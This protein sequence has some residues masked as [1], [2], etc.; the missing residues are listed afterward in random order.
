[1][2]HFVGDFVETVI[3]RYKGSI[4]TWEL[5]GRANSADVLALGEE[6]LLRLAVHA[7][8]TS[9]AIDADARYV[10]RIGQPWGQYLSR[11]GRQLAPLHFADT[12]LRAD[13]GVSGFDLEICVGYTRD[14]SPPRDLMELSRLL[15]LWSTLGVPLALTLAYPSAADT[16]PLATKDAAMEP[17]AA[18]S[19]WNEAAQAQWVRECVS[20]ALAKP[21]VQTVAWA[22]LS[23]AGPHEWP[24]A[25]LVRAD[26][27]PKRALEEL[28]TLR[29]QFLR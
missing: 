23:D 29:G 1:L 20:L 9:R 28:A 2:L 15:D 4:H 25:G 12:L 17:S 5:V 13:L 6:Q 14:A 27:A 26:G 3:R 22:H 8:E 7:L 19:P 18:E 24:H 16:D 11:T 21:N 10:I